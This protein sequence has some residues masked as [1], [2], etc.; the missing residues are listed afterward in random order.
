MMVKLYK[1]SLR[2]YRYLQYV[3]L[4]YY[5]GIMRTVVA[6]REILTETRKGVRT[7]T[8]LN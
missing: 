3:L 4:S 6:R 8:V 1:A 2:T 5:I 7:V